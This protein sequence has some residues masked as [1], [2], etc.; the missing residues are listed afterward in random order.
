MSRH[1]SPRLAHLRSLDGLRGAAV[2][3]VVAH[4]LG[5][6]PGGF[7][8]VDVF[9]VLSGFLIT[10]L[11]LV[12]L[13]GTGSVGL[14][15]FWGRRIRRL[16]PGLVVLLGA[17]AL[18]GAVAG[19]VPSGEVMRRDLLAALTYTTNWVQ[20]V[21]GGRY[22][23]AMG[24]PS[25]LRH[26]WSLALEEQLYLAWPLLVAAAARLAPRRRR[27]A[28]GVVAAA[29]AAGSVVALAALGD[30]VD[31]A[32]Y[33]T[34]TRAVAP[35]AGALVAVLAARPAGAVDPAVG[36]RRRGVAHTGGSGPASRW[37]PRRP[38][39]V[40][41][42][43][44]AAL[45]A[46]MLA[47]RGSSP[48]LYR[49]GFPAVALAAAALVWSLSVDERHPV[50][51]ALSVRPL[52]HLGRISYASYLWHWPVIVA[53]TPE[54]TGL[55]GVV[56]DLVRV[57]ATLAL[58]EV[59]TR[60]VEEPVRARRT[61]GTRFALAVPAGAVV[62]AAAALALPT[63]GSAPPGIGRV[64]PPEGVAAPPVGTPGAPIVL[65]VGDSTATTL[66]MGWDWST[67]AWLETADV[68]G[69]GMID[70]AV[71]ELPDPRRRRDCR[72]TV[73]R[74]TSKIDT[75]RPDV[76]VVSSGAWEIVDARLD[77]ERLVPGTTRWDREL[78]RVL[79]D[80]A[81][82]ARRVEARLVLLTAPCF[83]QAHDLD[84]LD[85]DRNDPVRVAAYNEVL[86]EVAGVHDG[87]EVVDLGGWIC[88]GGEPRTLAGAPLR[89]DGVHLDLAAAQE[90]WRWLRPRILDTP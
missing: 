8:A 33:G 52:R 60:V 17:L 5:R 62:V 28:V 45:G 38:A 1:A 85:D 47:A 63:S 64:E 27:L 65:L 71:V 83:E 56:L 81:D 55:H 73:A 31:R 25:P 69:C 20:I 80:L 66:G 4:H 46:A 54:R 26:A 11:L 61:P 78:R 49:W 22:W 77:G 40:G 59:S 50:A 48:W 68:L 43:A 89:A 41:G 15:A 75:V 10:G 29:L 53:L 16:V 12:E 2:V 19:P 87:V 23:E 9:F 34:D 86:D 88:P 35:L 76:V 51:R 7:L 37:A 58:A 72:G 13:E 24:P 44:V 14:R 30:Q 21:V 84:A 36:V 74:W 90:A 39:L 82:R 32:Y 67:G 70:E 79:A 42:V 6:F 3:L 18:W 57:A